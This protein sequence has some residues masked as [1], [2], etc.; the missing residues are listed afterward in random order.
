MAEITVKNRYLYGSRLNGTERPDSD[1][2]YLYVIDDDHIETVLDN[3]ETESALVFSNPELDTFEYDAHHI[4]FR[5]MGVMFENPDINTSICIVTESHFKAMIKRNILWVLELIFSEEKNKLYPETYS[6]EAVIDMKNLASATL[7]EAYFAR[8]KARIFY[9]KGDIRKASKNIY[10]AHKFI[11]YYDQIR[12]NGK[13]I[14]VY[15]PVEKYYRTY[16]TFEEGRKS[17]RSLDLPKIDKKDVGV[18]RVIPDWI[19][20]RQYRLAHYDKNAV[21]YR[22]DKEETI[23]IELKDEGVIRKSDL[24]S[25]FGYFEIIKLKTT[26]ILKYNFSNILAHNC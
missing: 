18:V 13:I 21:I 2:D 3:F 6:E 7:Y 10:Y 4:N 14:S 24:K 8:S 17:F 5:F 23:E 22:L 26:N 25:R 15:R 1:T 11:D 20:F 12:D 16:E 9:K 19:E